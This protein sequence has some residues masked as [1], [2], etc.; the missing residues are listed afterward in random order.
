MLKISITIPVFNEETCL[1]HSLSTLHG[2]LSQPHTFKWEIT[3]ADNG[4]TDQTHELASRFA[5]D[6]P[7]VSVVRLPERGRGRALKQVWLNNAA[8]ILSYMDADLSTDLEYFSR[9]VE[10]LISDQY[11]LATGS[12][13]LKPRLT[14]RCFKREFI[15]HCYNL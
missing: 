5:A 8:D 7:G 15:S 3:I 9:L 13:L 1:E 12:R 6:H 11:D 2:Y 10:P 4:S 14:T